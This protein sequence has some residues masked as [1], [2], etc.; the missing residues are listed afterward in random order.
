MLAR[1]NTAARSARERTVHKALVLRSSGGTP[2]P[3]L[4]PNGRKKRSER[5][6]KLQFRLKW[7]EAIIGGEKILTLELAVSWSNFLSLSGL[8]GDDVH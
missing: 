4:A 3:L 1:S 6:L 5:A 7:R 8:P 2:T